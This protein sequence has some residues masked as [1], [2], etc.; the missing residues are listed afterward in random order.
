MP[1]GDRLL[2]DDEEV[3]AELRP[4]PVVLFAPV[5]LVVIA[6]AG[7]IAIGV[8][9]PDA[10]V[11]VVWVLAAM[12]ALPAVWLLA[13][14]VRWRGVR[15]LVTDTRLLYRRGV[16]GRDLVQLRLQRVAEVHCVQSFGDRL[17][18]CG[19]LVF[20]VTGDDP[21]LVDDVRR[22]KSVQRL[23]GTQLDGL[24][25]APAAGRGRRPDERAWT[26]PGPT[27]PAPGA[28]PTVGA[29]RTV[30]GWDATPPHGVA[31]PPH[32]VAGPPPVMGGGSAGASVTERLIQL[33]ELRRRGIIS[34]EEFVAKKSELLSRL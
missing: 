7:A 21:L 19:R 33:D 6:F 32:G 15:L 11:A 23:I 1:F 8:K 29:A 12:V 5:A 27:R 25:A 4:H 20:E 28:V 2:A 26:A 10:P 13:R 3:L 22:P 18:G 9:F 24:D 17:V 30:P 34:D 31:A 16:L 14:V